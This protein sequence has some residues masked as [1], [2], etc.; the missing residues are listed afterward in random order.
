[1]ELKNGTELNDEKAKEALKAQY[2]FSSNGIIS[3]FFHMLTA[4]LLMI[5][6]F[7]LT[8][9]LQGY[10]VASNVIGV[11]LFGIGTAFSFKFA[12]KQ[13]RKHE[14]V[15]SDVQNDRYQWRTA[16]ILE[17][18][19]SFRRKENGQRKYF[20]VLYFPGMEEPTKRERVEVTTALY[21]SVEVGEEVYVI[22]IQSETIPAVIKKSS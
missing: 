15:I 22:Y 5:G 3:I 17:K 8:S 16:V 1:M 10:N 18:H 6:L 13:W 11:L 21:E 14:K 19:E 9:A 20:G 7:A 2:T 12:R 4:M